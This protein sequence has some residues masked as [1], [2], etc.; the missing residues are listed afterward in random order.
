MR[1]MNSRFLLG[2][3]G[4][5]A[6][7]VAIGVGGSPADPPAPPKPN[8]PIEHIVVIFGENVSF[9]HYFGTYPN[10]ANPAGQ[11]AFYPRADTP[12]LNNFTPQLL[13][14][15]PNSFN[16]RRLDR[17]E[18]VTCD[19]N[20]AYAPEQAAY[21][22]GAMDKFVQNTTGGSCTQS[23][24]KNRSN[25]GPQGIVMGYYDGNTVTAW[26]NLAQHFTMSDN[27]FTTTFGQSTI[28]AINLV[29]ANT[30]GVQLHG[31]TSSNVRNG[32]MVNNVEPLYDQCANPGNQL[33]TDGTV[34]GVTGFY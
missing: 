8:T 20:H 24:T 34:G 11:Q 32:T 12:A 25:Y 7:A 10:A 5:A 17:S 29:G 4:V 9:D 23:T 15:N 2:A 31:G 26:W 13:N 18:A 28:G 16:P 21:N 1:A 6:I 14:N 27:Y 30:Y 19:Q 33:N 22:R 3:A